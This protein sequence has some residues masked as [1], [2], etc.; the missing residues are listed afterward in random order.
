[1]NIAKGTYQGDEQVPPKNVWQMKN[2][3]SIYNACYVNTLHYISYVN[4]CQL[5]T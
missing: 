2:S 1:M 3:I 5:V 4:F